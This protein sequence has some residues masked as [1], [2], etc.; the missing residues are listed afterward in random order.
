MQT[1][2]HT[3]LSM[4]KIIKLSIILLASIFILQ[5][6][7]NDVDINADYEDIAIVYGLLNPKETRHYIKLTK[8]F[9]SDGNI[10]IAAKDG[11]ISSY[12]PSE[13]EI[14][15]D[16]Y[17]GN[18]FKRTILFD[19]LSVANKDSGDFYYPNQI[20]W[21]TAENTILNQ[22]YT[23]KLYIKNKTLGKEIKA[24]TGLVGDF[25]IGY[26][27]S[28]QKYVSFAGINPQE[29]KWASGVSGMLYQV[30]IRFFYTETN[31]LGQSSSHYVDMKL[32]KVKASSNS[33]GEA[34]SSSVS[35]QSFYSNLGGRISPAEAGM[36]RYSDSLQYIFDVADEEFT[37]YMDVNSAVT[38]IVQERPPYTN[39]E[40]GIGIFASRNKVVRS[41]RGLNAASL[42][43]LYNGVYT[44]DLGFIDR[45][46]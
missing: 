25:S 44:K 40:N 8:A 14:Y 17:N 26:P 20:I 4:I 32:A 30:T 39:I 46:L 31:S 16:E 42:D 43:S 34:L 7:D 19:T 41:V 3:K 29:I 5:S 12:D 33:G 35:G 1:N 22:N 15:M 9:L 28:S 6:C 45:P 37:I 24:T 13:I 21:A 10:Y 27:S 23:Y 38:S 36:Y 18:Y 2:T 11:S